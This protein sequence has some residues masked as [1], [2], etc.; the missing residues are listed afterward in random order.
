MLIDYPL[1]SAVALWAFVLGCFLCGVYDVLRLFRLGRKQNPLLLFFLDVAFCVFA[2][3]SFS[4][5]FFNL[6]Y[7]R[8]RA[9]A[10]LFGG[11]GFLVWRLTVSRLFMMILLKIRNSILRFLNVIKDG[12]LKLLKA[13]SCRIYTFVYCRKMVLGAKQGFGIY[14]K[15]RKENLKNAT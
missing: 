8:M 4:V 11:I 5:L 3:C 7:G 13:A 15:I 10:F 14:K 6:S 1:Q 9:Y 2:S 12:I